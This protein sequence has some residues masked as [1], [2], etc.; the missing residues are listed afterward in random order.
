MNFKLT[1]KLFYQDNDFDVLTLPDKNANQFAIA[2]ELAKYIHGSNFK[3][4]VFT[5]NGKKSRNST[6]KQWSID[7]I[8]F[9][10]KAERNFRIRNLMTDLIHSGIRL[11]IL[12]HM[13]EN[14]SKT[15]RTRKI[16]TNWK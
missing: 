10:K 7:E 11:M 15:R 5:A 6:R 9:F 1:P 8:N 12:H 13:R 16:N 14:Y 2:I 3:D 4:M